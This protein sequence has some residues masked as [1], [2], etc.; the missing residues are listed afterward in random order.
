MSGKSNQYIKKY[1]KQTGKLIWTSQEIAGGAKAI[2]NLYVVDDKVI[3]QIGGIVQVKGIFKETASNSTGQS[4]RV[5][6]AKVY[7]ESV[8]PYGVQ[9]FIATDGRFVW[10]QN[11]LKTVSQIGIDTATTI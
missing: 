11:A 9:A 5:D 1:D 10:I 7:D 6:V 2:P 3:V 4:V 8:K